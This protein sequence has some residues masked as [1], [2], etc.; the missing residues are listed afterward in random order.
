M[1]TI[2]SYFKDKNLECK[3]VIEALYQAGDTISIAR[4]FNGSG[5]CLALTEA[6][7]DI[8]GDDYLAHQNGYFFMEAIEEFYNMMPFY[9]FK[10][11]EFNSAY[12]VDDDCYKDMTHEERVDLRLTAMA[13]M[14]THLEDFIYG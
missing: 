11:Q 3:F 13:F 6:L 4:T 5:I 9:I 8:Y 14:I 12:M 7:E 10:G 1:H 2:A